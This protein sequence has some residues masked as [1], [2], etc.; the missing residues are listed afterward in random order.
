MTRAITRAEE[1]NTA[2]SSG[3]TLHPFLNFLYDYYLGW[4]RGPVMPVRDR[5]QTIGYQAELPQTYKGI[6]LD[7]GGT[8]EDWTD[9]EEVITSSTIAIQDFEE[10][11]DP[12]ALQR[13]GEYLGFLALSLETVQLEGT[14]P[15]AEDVW[16]SESSFS[17]AFWNP[18]FPWL[19]PPASV[20]QAELWTAPGLLDAWGSK[21][22]ERA[23]GLE[24]G[25][26]GF[27]EL[28]GPAD[29]LCFSAGNLE[30]T[31]K[32]NFLAPLAIVGLLVWTLN[33]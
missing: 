5:E 33:A 18:F 29:F 10:T 2:G 31:S 21:L 1:P 13:A 20:D 23:K 12:A 27:G 8:G 26:L 17:A 7:Y 28:A 15:P 9:I 25:Q 32:T 30:S 19:H 6:V 3:C 11:R 16:N 24:S 22:I 4:D 14:Y